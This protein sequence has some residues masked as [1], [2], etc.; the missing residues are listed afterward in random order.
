MTLEVG[1]AD[2]PHYKT[3][4]EF[5]PLIHR[6]HSN[7][8][9]C[10]CVALDVSSQRNGEE[11]GKIFW[12][13]MEQSVVKIRSIVSLQN[14]NRSTQIVSKELHPEQTSLSGTGAAY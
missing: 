3:Q 12:I 8:I 6:C 14:L 7:L 9:F 5:W 11:H 4:Q 13:N 2:H 1:R 10:H